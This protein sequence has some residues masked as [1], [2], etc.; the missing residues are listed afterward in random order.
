MGSFGAPA[1]LK[2]G[3]AHSGAWSALLAGWIALSWSTPS[4]AQD[5]AS[6]ESPESTET[7]GSPESPIEIHGF[8]SQG[9]ILSSKNEYLAKS[10]GGSFEFSE[11]AL[12]FTKPLTDE[13]RVGFQLFAH[14]L[15]PIGN[16]RPQLDWYYL[17]YRAWDWLGFRAGR[18]KVPFGLYNEYNDIDVARVPILLPQ[19]IYQVDHREFLFAQAGA[20]LYGD[21]RLGPAGSLEYRAYGG[22]LSSDLPLPPPTGITPS[23][24]NVPYLY[25]GRLLW[26]TPLDGLRAGMSG[27][28]VRFDARYDFDP[29]LRA[30]FEQATLLPP[31]LTY[32][33]P[34]K[35]RV[36]RWIASLEYVA[37]DLELAAEYSRWTGEFYSDAPVLFPPHTVNERYYAMASYQV[38]PW[39]SPGVYY[40][41][42][43]INIDDR[44][45][46]DKYQHD[47]SATLRIDL[48]AHWLFKLEGHLMSGVA[49]LDNRDLNGLNRGVELAQLTRR[50][51]LFLLKTT[52]YF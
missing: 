40:S 8:L 9:F 31:G 33:I 51:A 29:L 12:N 28:A 3:R 13:L 50:W 52:A 45:G 19:S 17:D 44:D 37:H 39:F 21:L 35:F 36:T 20:E 1:V 18:L 4:A 15:G 23:E 30:L 24:V 38:T 22:T 16:Y 32:P 41:R 48:N 11:A 42:Y 47:L 25:G 26:A 7:L 5:G 14:D 2:T 27:Q 46:H 43:F 6:P 34:I 49:A 10:K